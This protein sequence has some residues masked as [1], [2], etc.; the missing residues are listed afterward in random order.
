[1]KILFLVLFALLAAVSSARGQ[2]HGH[3]DIGA[4]GGSAK[5]NPPKLHAAGHYITIFFPSFRRIT[6]NCPECMM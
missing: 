1:M 2:D 6:A 5:P 3:L 4:A